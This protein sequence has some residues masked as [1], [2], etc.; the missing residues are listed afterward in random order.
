M[1]V[2][3]GNP[4][5]E[6]AAHR[7]NVGFMVVEELAR[8]AGQTLGQKKFKGRFT[9]A[10]VANAPAVLLLPET[11]MNLSGRSVA[12]AA[13]F[14]DVDEGDIVVVHDEL[15]LPFGRVKVK[16]G[17]GHGGHNGLRSI[18][19]D[20][21]IRDFLRVR[22]GI[23]RP[24]RGDATDHVLSPFRKDEQ[25]EL[26]FLIDEAADAVE[27]L[28]SEGFRASANEINGPAKDAG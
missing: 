17:G 11:F 24:L 23:G 5:P 1:V 10:L 8:R 9:T 20:A 14:Y 21:G 18:F 16:D 6:Y 25:Q 27:T 15:D 22:V 13:G 28:L 26:G 19:Q 7:H 12:S 4:G 2:G 3:L